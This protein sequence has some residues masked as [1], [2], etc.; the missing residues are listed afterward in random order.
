[1]DN[2]VWK[3]FIDEKGET[4][5]VAIDKDGKIVGVIYCPYIPQCFTDSTHSTIKADNAVQQ[6]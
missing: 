2:V 5:Q 6:K 3:D 1:M 4:F